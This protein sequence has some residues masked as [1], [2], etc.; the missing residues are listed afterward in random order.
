[1]S[2]RAGFFVVLSGFLAAAPAYSQDQN[3]NWAER[4]F[5]ELSYD[6]GTIARG[7]DARH[8]IVVTNI[9][10]EDVTIVKV[11]TTCG[12]TAA[13]PDRTLLKTHDQASIE[14]QMDTKKFMRRKD[15]NVIVTLTFHGQKGSSTRDV[16]IPITSYIRTDVVLTPGNA[17]FGSLEYGAGAERRIEIAYAGRDNWKIEDVRIGHKNIEAELREVTRSAGRVTYELVVRL[18]PNTR[19]GNIQEQINLITNDSNAD[20]VPLL[21]FGRVEPDIIVT[22]SLQ[23]LGKMKPGQQKTFSVVLRGKRPFAI[24][25]IESE[26]NKDSFEVMQTSDEAKLQ[27]IIPF[28]MTAPSESGAF[29]EQLSFSIAGRSEPITLRAEGTISAD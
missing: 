10:E 12:C 3:L 9:Y 18:D 27:H 8:Y 28:R 16:R 20:T 21:V 4:M 5:S 26:T 29:A 1:M 2:C 15:S 17:D 6:F 14:I 22:P 11:D 7:A 19:M 13:K 24:Q 25:N 23:Q